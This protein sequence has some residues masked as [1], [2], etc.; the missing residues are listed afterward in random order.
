MCKEN[1]VLEKS[2]NICTVRYNCPRVLL[3]DDDKETCMHSKTCDDNLFLDEDGKHCI[4]SCENKLKIY[5]R[6]TGET[7][8][9]SSCPVTSPVEKDGFCRSCSDAYDIYHTFWNG[10]ECVPCPEELPNLDRA[11]KTCAPA[12]PA[13]KPYW[14]D[15]ECLDC[16]TRYPFGD[17][18]FWDP[19]L[20]TCVDSCPLGTSADDSNTCHTCTDVY[21]DALPL[22]D[23]E[24]RTC[25]AKCKETSV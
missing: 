7:Q 20:E 8:C 14:N 2:G 21:G 6:T 11:T 17:M 1:A 12:C 4:S 5:N 3:S 16:R 15:F 13:D 10:E 18:P 23:P 25:V 22:W 9:V 24:S 19:I